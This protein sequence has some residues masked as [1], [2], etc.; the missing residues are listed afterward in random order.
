MARALEKVTENISQKLHE[1]PNLPREIMAKL[2]DQMRQLNRV[3]HHYIEKLRTKKVPA[4][5]SW[6]VGESDCVPR[7]QQEPDVEAREQ[8]R[9]ELSTARACGGI[10]IA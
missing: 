1:V 10:D 7:H 5:E 2:S 8:T 3:T 6:A 4:K 9:L